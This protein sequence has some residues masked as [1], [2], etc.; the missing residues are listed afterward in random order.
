MAWWLVAALLLAAFPV[1]S[2]DDVCAS[3][4][5][6]ALCV[7]A[8]SPNGTDANTTNVGAT[9]TIGATTL[10]TGASPYGVFVVARGQLY[11]SISGIGIYAAPDGSPEDWACLFYAASLGSSCQTA[12]ELAAAM[13]VDAGSYQNLIVDA[14]QMLACDVR[15]LS[16]QIP[17]G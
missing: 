14:T 15:A 12:E 11:S 16:C 10:S 17:L 2:A 7:V 1:A 9:T 5:P 4:G 6:A 13:G 3:W 8:E